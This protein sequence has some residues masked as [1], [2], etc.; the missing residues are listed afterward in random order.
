ITTA[1]FCQPGPR[2]A[3]G[4]FGE[5]FRDG[6]AAPASGL[7]SDEATLVVAALSKCREKVIHRVVQ[8]RNGEGGAEPAVRCRPAP[9]LGN[10]TPA[11]DFQHPL[12]FRGRQVARILAPRADDRELPPVDLS[13]VA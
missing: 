7:E 6:G 8:L 3:R 4:S 9:E 10:A 2:G 1:S 5:E 13:P 12:H 11:R